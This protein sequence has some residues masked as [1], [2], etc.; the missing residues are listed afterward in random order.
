MSS[1]AKIGVARVVVKTELQNL[2]RIE[3]EL[4][5][6][7]NGSIESSGRSLKIFAMDMFEARSLDDSHN[8]SLKWRGIE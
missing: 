1:Q 4:N 6:C 5:G 2:Y 3:G 7:L 8:G